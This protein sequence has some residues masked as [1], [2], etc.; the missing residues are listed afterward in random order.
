MLFA[1]IMTQILAHAMRI[2]DSRHKVSM[3]RSFY[4][5]TIIPIAIVYSVSLIC[6][7]VAYL[8]LSVS[9]IQMMQ[10]SPP[11]HPTPLPPGTSS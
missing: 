1:S 3:A 6:G 4:L 11:P 2:L 5:K 9:F 10:V 7:N 8:F